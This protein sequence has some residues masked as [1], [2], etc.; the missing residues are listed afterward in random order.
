MKKLLLV[1]LLVFAAILPAARA[2]STHV[3][4]EKEMATQVRA[5]FLH[6]WEGYHKYAWGGTMNCAH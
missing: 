3:P 5:Q 2:A 6:A 1:L 4:S